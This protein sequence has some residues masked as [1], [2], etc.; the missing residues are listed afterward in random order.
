MSR[1]RKSIHQTLKEVGEW[2]S[3]IEPTG[4][5]VEQNNGL[6]TKSKGLQETI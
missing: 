5:V 3:P 6:M 4:S 2:L 1:Y